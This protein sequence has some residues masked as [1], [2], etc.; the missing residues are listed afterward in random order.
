M[1]P[2]RVCVAIALVLAALL[3]IPVSL[4][5]GDQKLTDTIRQAKATMCMNN[6]TLCTNHCSTLAYAGDAYS[7]CMQDCAG[8]YSVCMSSI[9]R[10][11]PKSEPSV[12]NPHPSVAPPKPTPRK[13][14]PERVDG[15]STIKA[16]PTASP[17]Q[18]FS[19][20]NKRESPFESR[21]TPASP[22]PKPAKK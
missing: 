2:A 6:F 19:T 4:I 20:S 12:L 22:T 14:A 11:A 16:S 8:K 18:S 21:K 10:R 5:F 7:I 13:I 1:K 17:R 3:I 15:V 9:T